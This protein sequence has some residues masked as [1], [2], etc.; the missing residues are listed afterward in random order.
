[1]NNEF[2]QHLKDLFNSQKVKQIFNIKEVEKILVENKNNNIDHGN[3]L[4]NIFCLA[5][6]INNNKLD[7]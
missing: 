5:I 4:F 6:W 7:I 3:K 1:M 2:N